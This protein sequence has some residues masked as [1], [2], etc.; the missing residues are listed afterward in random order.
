MASKATTKKA[1]SK[2]A[3][4]K[5]A[6]PKKV[7][8]KKVVTK[9]QPAKKAPVKKQPAVKKTIAKQKDLVKKS[10]PLKSNAESAKTKQ[11]EAIKNMLAESGFKSIEVVGADAEKLNEVKDKFGFNSKEF[12]DAITEVV[13]KNHPHLKVAAMSDRAMNESDNQPV[14]EQSVNQTKFE[15]P[16]KTATEVIGN[17]VDDYMNCECDAIEVIDALE[18][19]RNAL[20]T[21]VEKD[22]LADQNAISERMNNLKFRKKT[23]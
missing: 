6:A 4:T 10:F 15:E 14:I 18:L 9:K 3:P 23:V 16:K 19:V 1:T 11:R 7:A 5:K 12:R 22:Q 17:C 2:K 8:A 21:K 13:E 20:I